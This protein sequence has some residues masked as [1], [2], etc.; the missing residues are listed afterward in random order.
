[1]VEVDRSLPEG[2]PLFKAGKLAGLVLLGSRFLG[3]TSNKSYVVPV[4]RI[5]ALCSRL[6]T[7]SEPAGSTQA[8]PA[9]SR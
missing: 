7:G 3:E 4:D 9:A 1:L 5:A 2:T 6:E 8:A